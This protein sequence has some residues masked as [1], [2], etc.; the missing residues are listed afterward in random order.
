MT[1][2]VSSSHVATMTSLLPDDVS[3]SCDED[4]DNEGVD[5]TGTSRSHVV[6][7]IVYYPR[8]TGGSRCVGKV[9]SGVASVTVCLRVSA[10]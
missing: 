1:E 6:V 2:L 7:I 4:V 3:S 9:I 5:H 8:R 10:L